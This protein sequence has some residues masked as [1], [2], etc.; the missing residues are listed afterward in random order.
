[1]FRLS[2]MVALLCLCTTTRQHPDTRSARSLTHGP[3]GSHSAHN[4]YHAYL[5]AHA[6]G[7]PTVI[8]L[9]ERIVLTQDLA[10]ARVI[11]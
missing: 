5:R 2:S 6:S 11:V 4:T 8:P 7:R 10:A 9:L 3:L 1:M